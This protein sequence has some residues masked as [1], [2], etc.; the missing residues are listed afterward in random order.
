MDITKSILKYLIGFFIL[1]QLIPVTYEYENKKVDKTLEINASQEMM[2]MFK[3][4]CYDC[5]SYETKLPWYGNVAPFSWQ[6]KR[7]IELGRKWLN[8]STWEQYSDEQKDK[9]LKEIYKAVYQSMPLKSYIFA[10]PESDL[11]KEERNKIRQWTGK[12]PFE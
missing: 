8:F 2:S 11:S 4:S 6:V 9:K 5:H 1:I 3:R 7:H 10:H 12:S